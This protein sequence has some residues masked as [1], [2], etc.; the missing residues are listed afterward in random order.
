MSVNRSKNPTACKFITYADHSI[1]DAALSVI[2]FTM[3]PMLFNF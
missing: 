1:Y 2:K 3:L